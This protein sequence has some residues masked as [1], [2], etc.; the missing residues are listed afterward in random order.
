MTTETRAANS[1]NTPVPRAP[2]GH[3][4]PGRSPNPAGRPKKGLSIRDL[5]RA[6][7]LKDKRDL[8]AVAFEQAIQEKDVAWAN[9]IAKYSDE[10]QEALREGLRAELI[11]RQ[12]GDWPEKLT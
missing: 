4:L 2:N 11:I 3:W 1:E 9:W 10:I 6:R 8:I 7:P 5:L 12:Y